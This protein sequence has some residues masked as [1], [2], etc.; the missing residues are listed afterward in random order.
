MK[1]YQIHKCAGMYEDYLEKI[2]GSYINK[3][4]AEKMLLDFQK[5]EAAKQA[6]IEK[7]QN[8]TIN[9][10]IFCE[11]LKKEKLEDEETWPENYFYYRDP[12]Y[13]KLEEVEVDTDDLTF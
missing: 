3:K 11:D 13:Y 1:I 6:Q 4:K 12:V 5:S 9:D 8:Y 10:K 7:C 2:V